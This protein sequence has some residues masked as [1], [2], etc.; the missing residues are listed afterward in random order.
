MILKTFSCPECSTNLVLDVPMTAAKDAQQTQTEWC[1]KCQRTTNFQRVWT[2]TAF[3]FG[4]MTKRFTGQ[5]AGVSGWGT[6]TLDY[7]KKNSDLVAGRAQ[8]AERE[9]K[10]AVAD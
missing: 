2:P 10:P 9:I 6:H 3:A 5:A 4:L 7:G 8:E 1:P